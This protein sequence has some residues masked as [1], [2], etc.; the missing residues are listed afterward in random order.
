M[1]RLEALSEDL[2]RMVVVNLNEWLLADGALALDEGD[3]LASLLTP[4]IRA[5][6]TD[7]GFERANLGMQVCG[8]YGYSAEYGMEQ[9]VRDARITQIYEGTNGIQALD[10]VACKLGAHFGRNLRRFLHPRRRSDAR[11]ATVRG[12]EGRRDR[13]PL[14][15]SESQSA[16]PS[17]V[18]KITGPNAGV[19]C[20]RSS[21]SG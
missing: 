20:A 11:A 21:K 17:S 2:F 1:E 5:F 16:K 14:P 6:Q 10:L 18:P 4:V 19:I 7:L 9:L 12:R 13:P 15:V 3:D 8:G